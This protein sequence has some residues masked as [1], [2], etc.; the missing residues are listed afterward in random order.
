MYSDDYSVYTFGCEEFACI[1]PSASCVDDDPVT[2]EMV[3]NC[4]NVSAPCC[5]P[6]FCIPL[7]ADLQWLKVLHEFNWWV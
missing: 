5:Y 1:D 7:G 3:E 2:A 6:A 4:S